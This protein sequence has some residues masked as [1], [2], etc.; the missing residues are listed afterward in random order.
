MFEDC[1]PAHTARKHTDT[2]CGEPVDDV[3]PLALPYPP[4]LNPM[5]HF[6]WTRS[7]VESKFNEHV[8]ASRDAPKGKIAEVVENSVKKGVARACACFQIHVKK[9]IDLEEGH[10]E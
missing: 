6:V 5:N 7:V 2:V 4:D 1:A 10:M 9:V 3:D 8:V